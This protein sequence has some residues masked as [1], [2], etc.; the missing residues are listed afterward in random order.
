MLPGG[1]RCSQRR[2][3]LDEMSSFFPNTYRL[4]VPPM[5]AEAGVVSI[6]CPPLGRHADLAG[7]LAESARA[8]AAIAHE[9]RRAPSGRVSATVAATARTAR[10]G[11]ASA[12][13]D[14]SASHGCLG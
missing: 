12:R 10:Y 9:E 1:P 8:L 3:R 14:Q 4:A 7:A 6:G 13:G 11:L 2:C 5:L